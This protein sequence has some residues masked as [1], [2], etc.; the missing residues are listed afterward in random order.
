MDVDLASLPDPNSATPVVTPLLA[1]Q[2]IYNADLDVVAYELLFRSCADNQAEFEDGDIATSSVI[3]NAFTSLSVGEV[4]EG[5]PAYINFTKALL[6]N[7]VLPIG[8]E[9]LVVE[10]LED[11]D[12]DS[13]VLASIR[14]LKQ[15]GYTIVLDDYCYQPEHHELLMMADTVKLDVLDH[16]EA[17]LAEQ[18]AAIKPYGIT[19]LAEKVES[20]EMFKRC[21]ALGFELFQGNFLSKPFLVKGRKAGASQQ[22][23]MRMLALLEDPEVEFEAIESVLAADPRLSVKLLK[24]ANSAGAG[25]GRTIESIHKAI[26]ILGLNRIKSLAVLLSM[27]RCDDKPLA[28]RKTTMVRSRMCQLLAEQCEAAPDLIN[29]AFTVGLL[30]SLD[31]HLDIPLPSLLKELNLSDYV[32]AAILR[33]VDIEGVL[34]HTAICF[35]RAELDEINWPVLERLSLSPEQ[36]EFAYIDSLTWAE[37]NIRQLLC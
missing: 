10:V 4:L 19:L 3:L 16:D 34:L 1:R 21:K 24:L 26:V 2:A 32:Q 31:A 7:P 30:S 35:E 18:M 5:K 25:S 11:I 23:L 9:S 15:K 20:Y 8:P 14:S 29:S 17:G 13:Q 33:Y 6:H 22:A 27:S 36:V 28:L 37:E 12:I